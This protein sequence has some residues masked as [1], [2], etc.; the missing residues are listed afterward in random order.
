MNLDCDIIRDLLP[1]YVDK[2]TSEKSN[3]VIREHLANC[4]EC[5]QILSQMEQ[6]AEPPIMQDKK[7]DY[8]K[9]YRKNTNAML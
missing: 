7:I 9:A 2:L 6:E 5:K 8:L 4:A 3:I 1:S